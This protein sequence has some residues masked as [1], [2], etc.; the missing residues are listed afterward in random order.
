MW[1]ILKGQ[2]K[3][4]F[5]VRFILSARDTFLNLLNRS[6]ASIAMVSVSQVRPLIV[7]SPT[8]LP[9][10]LLCCSATLVKE[11]PRHTVMLP[12]LAQQGR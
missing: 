2:K 11:C 3:S 10:A 12:T 9:S 1:T 5:W 7:S 6:P 4:R 8:S